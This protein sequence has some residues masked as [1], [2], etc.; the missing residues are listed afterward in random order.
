MELS[1][2]NA[3]KADEPKN[4]HQALSSADGVP[5]GIVIEFTTNSSDSKIYPGIARE[6]NKFGTPDKADLFADVFPWWG[7]FL[8]P[9]ADAA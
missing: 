2:V 8:G 6:A 4:N 3:V 5:K 7:S 1:M 9:I